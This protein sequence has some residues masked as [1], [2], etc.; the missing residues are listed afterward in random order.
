M[1]IRRTGKRASFVNQVRLQVLQA[2][3]PATVAV[4]GSIPV[5][6]LLHVPHASPVNPV[7]QKRKAVMTVLLER[8]TWM[9]MQQQFAQP[10]NL[11]ATHH[12]AVYRALN[13]HKVL[14]T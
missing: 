4:P 7:L 9:K 6:L 5:V 12:P 10:V 1:G 11:E 3:L 14:Q 8:Q 2:P 13:A